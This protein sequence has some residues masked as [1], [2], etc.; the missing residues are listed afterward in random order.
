[1][2]EK[3]LDMEKFIR[4]A[5]NRA[6]ELIIGLMVD[7]GYS[8]EEAKRINEDAVSKIEHAFD[9]IEMDMTRCLEGWIVGT[10]GGL[11][12]CPKCKGKKCD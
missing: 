1:M 12:Q 8:E 3:K 5:R 10:Y 7:A 4:S 9:P 6:D 2:A 11:T